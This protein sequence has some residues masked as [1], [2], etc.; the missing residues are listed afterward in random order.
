MQAWNIAL[1]D[2]NPVML[3]VNIIGGVRLLQLV[4]DAGMNR[5]PLR[6]LL[7]KHAYIA[8]LI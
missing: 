7:C 1:T 2:Q 6:E 8:K 3:E 5:D 4:V